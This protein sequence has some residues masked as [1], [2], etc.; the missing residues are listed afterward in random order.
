MVKALCS[1]VKILCYDI[2]KVNST[3]ILSKICVHLVDAPH[4]VSI[5]LQHLELGSA[6]IQ[7]LNSLL[8]GQTVLLTTWKAI[9]PVLEVSEGSRRR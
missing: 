9:S 1:V 3:A 2:A 7:D 8:F 6:L 4:I 5:E